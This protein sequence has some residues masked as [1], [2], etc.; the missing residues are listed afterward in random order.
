MAWSEHVNATGWIAMAWGERVTPLAMELDMI[1]IRDIAR[2]LARQCRFNGHLE[3][4]CSVAE[5]SVHVMWLTGE[6]LQREGVEDTR[7][8]RTAL[9]HDATEAYLGDLVRPLKKLPEFSFF[10][11]A[12]S[13]LYSVIARK[14]DLYDPIPD[15]VMEAD[16]ERLR[17]ELG[18]RKSITF[19]SSFWISETMFLNAFKEVAP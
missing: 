7:M 16:D 13:Q 10:N 12:E 1:D 5:H 9:L 11:E 4:F 18:R 17:F 14:Y 6:A 2:S 8:L 19:G 3:G 15:M